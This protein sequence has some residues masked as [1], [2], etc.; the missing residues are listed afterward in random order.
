MGKRAFH[1]TKQVFIGLMICIMGMVL[2]NK[3]LFTHTHMMSDGTL[4]THSHL[5]DKAKESQTG[6]SHQH[7]KL[8]FQLFQNLQVLFV[9]AVGALTIWKLKGLVEK[10]FSLTSEFTPAFIELAHGRAPPKM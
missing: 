4:I 5:V 3:A 2:V 1:I 7:S 9:L 6:K 8:E 10:L